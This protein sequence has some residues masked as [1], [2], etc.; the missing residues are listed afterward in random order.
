MNSKS[1][2]K[3]NEIKLNELI[4]AQQLVVWVVGYEPEAHPR[5]FI[6]KIFNL[7]H[8]SAPQRTILFQSISQFDSFLFM[9][10]MEIDGF[11]L[12]WIMNAV[13]WMKRKQSLRLN[14]EWNSIEK[15]SA[16]EWMNKWRT[17]QPRCAASK[18]SQLHHFFLPLR[19]KKW[20]I[21]LSFVL[22]R[23]VVFLIAVGYGR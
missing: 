15:S 20:G 14:E 19:E 12:N 2:K 5:C 16:V 17:K 22:S 9:N 8:S 1:R 11:F 13:K 3:F 21:G 10:Q 7:F 18:A 6:S 4:A 23:S